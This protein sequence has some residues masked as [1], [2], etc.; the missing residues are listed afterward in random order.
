MRFYKIHFLFTAFVFLCLSGFSQNFSSSEEGMLRKAD[1]YFKRDSFAAALPLFSQLLSLHPKDAVF[2]YKFGVCLLNADRRDSKIPLKY[3]EFAIGKEGVSN[4]IHYY[5]GMAYHQNYRFN[6][7]IQEYNTYKSNVREG[8]IRKNDIDRK[9]EMCNNGKKL[10][11]NINDL[12]VLERKTVNKKDFFRSY[13]FSEFGGKFLVKLDKFKTKQDEKMND[14]SFVFYSDKNKVIYFSSYGDE[15]NS[16][17]DLY[18]SFQDKFG[19]WSN[20]EKLSNIINTEYDEDYPFLLPDGKTLYFC[21]KGHNSMGGYDIFKSIYN[22]Q[23]RTWSQPQN[24]DF[25]INTPFDDILFVSDSV[26]QYA[27][28]SSTRNTAEG[29]LSVYKVRI[30]KK[31]KAPQVVESKVKP[32]LAFTI[33][34]STYLNFL[35]D[36]ENLDVNATEDMFPKQIEIAKVENETIETEEK[37]EQDTVQYDNPLAFITNQLKA[38]EEEE[39]KNK[40][41]MESA[42]KLADEKIDEAQSLQF[43]ADSI[44]GYTNHYV[45]PITKQKELNKANILKKKAEQLEKEAKIA[46]KIGKQYEDKYISNQKEANNAAEYVQQIKKVQEKG[47]SDSSLALLSEY[48]NIQKNE[49][50]VNEEVNVI[51]EIVSLDKSEIKEIERKK[52]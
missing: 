6:E 28:F 49:P 17:R 47:N 35:M 14:N 39:Q 4:E 19:E 20:P 29:M 23:S 50:Q 27:Y 37:L 26:Q 24:L 30:D 45:D 51:E 10:L 3:L 41:Q 52:K 40:V 43:E 12:Y 42:Q 15:R 9:I 48:I 18:R 11:N 21:S 36:K 33:Q 8:E 7:A 5:L 25:A 16:N 31:I 32:E 38:A 13:N 34:D 2:S 22:S 1:R 44:I 46:R